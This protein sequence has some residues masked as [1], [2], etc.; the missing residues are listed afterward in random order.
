MSST[1]TYQAYTMAEA[2]AAVKYDLGAEA[3][4]LST[5]TFKRGGLLGLGRRTVVE[6]TASNTREQKMGGAGGMGPASAATQAKPLAGGNVAADRAYAGSKSGSPSSPASSKENVAAR[7]AAVQV[8]ASEADRQRNRRLAMAMQEKNRRAAEVAAGIANGNPASTAAKAAPQVVTVPQ[9]AR[10]PVLQAA[11]PM[12]AATGAA[13]P[14]AIPLAAT[15]R[16]S[17][18]AA[19]SGHSNNPLVVTVPAS[20]MSVAAKRF[21]L[22]SPE[23]ANRSN[24]EAA[25]VSAQVESHRFDSEM[26]GGAATATL[27]PPASSSASPMPTTPAGIVSI[28]A[29][30]APTA[31]GYGPGSAPQRS[32]SP[33]RHSLPHGEVNPQ[34]QQELAAIKNMV[35]QVLQRQTSAARQ[36]TPSMP[37]KLF[38]LYLRLVSHDLPDE[39]ADAIVNEMRQQLGPAEME[40]DATLRAAAIEQLADYIPVAPTPLTHVSPNGR[41]LTIALVGPTGVGK[42]T[43]LAKLAASFKLKAGRKVGLITSDTYRIAAVDQLRTY[44][45][46]IG[47]PLQVTL[48]PADMRNAMAS[49]NDCDVI[50]VDTAGRSQKDAMRIAE[51]R[52][53]IEAAHPHEVHMV[54]SSTASEKVLLSEAEAFSRVGVDKLILTKMDEAAS[55]GGL[56]SMLRMVGKPV[57][58][59]TTGQEVPD[60]LEPASARR[61]AELALGDPVHP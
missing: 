60:H 7:G 37:P 35:G 61:L 20:P 39:L 14:M 40:N 28:G 13:A 33:A 59:I 23:S 19:S 53:F 41:P 17:P 2:L 3:I 45:N 25:Q 6:V 15:V 48:T 1:R 30:P 52:Q 18:V 51:L 11:A 58:F 43:T 26:N 22:R 12:A 10:V 27:A 44:A 57:S 9:S 47:L 55:L 32:A 38:D 21:I 49:M 31:P 54:L 36:H 42:T 4:I 16:T 46:I 50:L 56:M 24:N 29:P 5:R 8:L 34:V